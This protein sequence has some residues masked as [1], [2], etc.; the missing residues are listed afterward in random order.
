MAHQLIVNYGLYRKMDVYEPH[1]AT[2]D[3][4]TNFH[5]KE[6]I[7]YLQEVSAKKDGILTNKMYNIGETDCPAFPGVI[8]FSEIS[9]GGS[10]DGAKL[11]NREETDIAINWG[12]NI[13]LKH[14]IRRS[15]SCQE[16]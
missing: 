11:I 1:S 16:I 13:Y 10:I 8:D 14:F 2:I 9:S 12:G 3:E 5:S 7:K 6:Y 4:L 15:T